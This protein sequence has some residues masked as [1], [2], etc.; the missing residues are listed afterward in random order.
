LISKEINEF[1]SF[2]EGI[3]DLIINPWDLFNGYFISPFLWDAMSDS[4]G[5]GGKRVKEHYFDVVDGC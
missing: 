4:R 2:L 1:D 5:V 3:F